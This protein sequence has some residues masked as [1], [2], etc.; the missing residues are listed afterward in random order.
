MKTGSQWVFDAIPVP[1]SLYNWRDGWGKC[2]CFEQVIA[3]WPG[4]WIVQDQETG[5]AGPSQSV[6][7]F[8]SLTACTIYLCY[9]SSWLLLPLCAVVLN[10][11]YL[12][13]WGFAFFFQF[14]FP[15]HWRVV[16][17]AVFVWAAAWGLAVA[18]LEPQQREKQTNAAI[19]SPDQGVN[20]MYLE[21][22][23]YKQCK[24]TTGMVA[25]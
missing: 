13:P 14:Y 23:S 18:V 20:C 7:C 2:R 11:S 22:K 25:S 21:N 10:F 19:H 16:V 9:C 8:V 15:C 24:P 6:L 5:L 3:T 1:C 4:K 12:S 17:M